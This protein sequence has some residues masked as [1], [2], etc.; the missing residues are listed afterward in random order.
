MIFYQLHLYT[1]HKKY[2]ILFF[3]FFFQFLKEN[4]SANRTHSQLNNNSDKIFSSASLMKISKE[5]KHATLSKNIEKEEELP[6][7]RYDAC[8]LYVITTRFL[9]LL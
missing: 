2:F 8:M 9:I 6:A 3:F 4:D 1:I 5:S 7:T